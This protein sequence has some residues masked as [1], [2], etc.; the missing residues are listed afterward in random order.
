M[1]SNFT[2]NPNTFFPPQPSL[3]S[4]PHSLL[5]QREEVVQTCCF[6]NSITHNRDSTPSTRKEYAHSLTA[7]SK[8]KKINLLIAKKGASV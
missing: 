7:K 1:A 5:Y 3:A 6:V 2:S 8:E 4:K